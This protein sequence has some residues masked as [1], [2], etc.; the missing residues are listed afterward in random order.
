M[1]QAGQELAPER[2]RRVCRIAGRF[3]SGKQIV[4]FGQIRYPDHAVF[5]ASKMESLRRKMRLARF[6]CGGLNFQ[7]TAVHA[8]PRNLAQIEVGIRL[9]AVSRPQSDNVPGFPVEPDHLVVFEHD[10]AR[11]AG[12]K[13]VFQ[14]RFPFELALLT[15][16]AR[17]G[18]KG[19]KQQDGQNDDCRLLQIAALFAEQHEP[20]QRRDEKTS[21]KQPEK[22]IFPP[23]GQNS[24]Q[25]ISSYT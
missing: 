25:F 6:T 3:Q 4:V 14:Q 13:H 19:C 5:A 1:I 2:L 22:E 12:G 21:R 24:L 7:R 9:R 18:K 11:R 17:P 20:E 8:L 23:H 15:G 10:D 16:F